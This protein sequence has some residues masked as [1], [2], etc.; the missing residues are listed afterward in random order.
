MKVALPYLLPGV[1]WCAYYYYFVR[2]ILNKQRVPLEER[3]WYVLFLMI[4][5]TGI[6]TGAALSSTGTQFLIS[7]V[8]WVFILIILGRAEER[9]K[10]AVNTLRTHSGILLPAIF[11]ATGTLVYIGVPAPLHITY[12]LTF[13]AIGG[14]IYEWELEE[15]T[16]RC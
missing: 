4:G 6:F 10:N 14:T 11:V 5:I 9:I 16:Q 15:K 2:E 7:V 12:L 1:F 13:I 3:I 8:I